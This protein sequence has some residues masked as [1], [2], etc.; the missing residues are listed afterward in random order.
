MKFQGVEKIVV[1]SLAVML[2]A[3]CAQINGM[4]GESET[5]DT[6]SA[7]TQAAASGSQSEKSDEAPPFGAAAPEQTSDYTEA[8]ESES[9]SGI[10]GDI[11]ESSPFSKI[12]IG[13]SS[14]QVVDLIGPPTDQNSYMTGKAWI[15]F[16]F[17][18]DQYRTEFRYKGMGV[19]TFAG[20]SGFS[21]ASK[22]YRVIYNPKEAGYV[23]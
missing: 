3:G 17:G 23:R 14:K 9:E 19:I 11:P 5:A 7:T 16:Y 8:T 18:S 1:V 6:N 15:P 22:V 13:M 10:Y 20:S 4:M 12:E 2:M 21:T